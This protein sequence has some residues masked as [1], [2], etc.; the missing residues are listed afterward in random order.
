METFVAGFYPTCTQ[1]VMEDV[2]QRQHYDVLGA[3][4][5]VKWGVK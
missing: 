4:M 2:M 5:G 1:P 3:E